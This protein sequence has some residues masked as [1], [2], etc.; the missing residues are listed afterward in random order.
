MKKYFFLF[1]YLCLLVFHISAQDFKLTG[2][3]EPGGLLIGI[4][5]NI[6]SV[7]LNDTK[8]KVDKN[9]LFALGFDRDAT[10]TYTLKIEYENGK[11]ET[12]K[13]QLPKRKYIIQKLKIA[14][15]YVNPPPEEMERIEIES[16]KMKEARS[17]VGKI[18]SALFSKGFIRPAEG[19][20]S[21][22]FGSQRVLNG[23]PK[24]PHNGI[25]IAAPEGTPVLATSDGVVIIAGSDFYYNG[26]FVLIDHGQGL[27]SIYLHMSKLNVKS[28]DKVARGQKIGEV[29]STG[30]STS[31]H[32]HWGVQW[33]G[34]R[35]DPMSLLNISF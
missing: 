7:Y 26:N 21:S 35:I 31:A 24:N 10:G 2:K 30:R 19:R 4:G 32:L 25:D 8:I 15:K 23:V 1:L 12:K 9:G 16:Q 22:V 11:K 5:K 6:S 13:I 33:Y 20:I 14:E 27:S 28:G 17:Q 3:A 29:G 18:D 34:N